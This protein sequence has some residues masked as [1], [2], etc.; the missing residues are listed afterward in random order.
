M[1]WAQ[2][3]H[4][5]CEVRMVL[6]SCYGWFQVNPPGQ[7]PFGLAG[8]DKLVLSQISIKWI[9][10]DSFGMETEHQAAT[11]F[12]P[13]PNICLAINFHQTKLGQM[14][15]IPKRRSAGDKRSSELGWFCDVG[16]ITSRFLDVSGFSGYPGSFKHLLPCS[17]KAT[18]S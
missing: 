1:R 13:I 9:D 2:C 3:S 15:R 5:T 12:W 14:L 4:P 10:H 17:T 18:L 11:R 7:W 8:K 6:S 16:A